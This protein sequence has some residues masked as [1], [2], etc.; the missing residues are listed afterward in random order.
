MRIAKD[1][2]LVGDGA[3]RIS[4]PIDCHVYLIESCEKKVLMDSG[5][6]IEPEIIIDNIRNDGLNPV[7]YY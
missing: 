6:G 2:Y 4:N 3:I 5:L 1:I 7:D